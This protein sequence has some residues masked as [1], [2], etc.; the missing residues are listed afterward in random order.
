MIRWVGIASLLLWC[1]SPLAAQTVLNPNTVEF[2]ASPDHAT[3]AADGTPILD[4]YDWLVVQSSPTGAL[5]MTVNLG[6]PTPNASNTITVTPSFATLGIGT[7]YYSFVEAVGP[8]GSSRSA[9]S[10]PFANQSGPRPT[11]APVVSQK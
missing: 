10:N 8:F 4:H 6:K 9:A 5:F 1:A 3:K 2:T 11:G 7:T